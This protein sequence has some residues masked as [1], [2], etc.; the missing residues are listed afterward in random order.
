MKM[1]QEASKQQNVQEMFLKGT[2]LKSKLDFKKDSGHFFVFFSLT[3]DVL[4]LSQSLYS[5]VLI[6]SWSRFM[7]T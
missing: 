6:R 7:Q 4:I 3:Y 5:V 1:V 2:L